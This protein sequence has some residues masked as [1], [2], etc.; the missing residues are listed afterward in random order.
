M[1]LPFWPLAVAI[2]VVCAAGPARAQIE[3]DDPD[4]RPRPPPVEPEE[5]GGETGGD[6]LDPDSLP[7]PQ[8]KP[9]QA[10]PGPE[11]REVKPPEKKAPEKK[12]DEKKPEQAEAAPKPAPLAPIVTARGTEADLE[13]LWKA[14]READAKGD[15][16]AAKKARV[17][18]V[19][20]AGDL[21]TS[22]LDGFAMSLVRSAQEKGGSGDHAGA[23]DDGLAAIEL[24]P[25][26][27][28]A[29]LG[30]A[31]AYL[32]ADPSELGRYLGQLG[33]GL[34]ALL[35]DVRYRRPAL[36][37]LGAALLLSVMAT[38]AAV[39]AMLFVRRGRYFLHDFHHLFPRAAARWQTAAFAFIL[40]SLPLVFRAG[41]APVLLV[42]F[43]AVTFY[44]RWAERAVA[45]VL[46]A[47][48]GLVP[49]GAEHLAE[50]TAFALTPAED[51]YR[52]DRGDV[53]ADVLAKQLAEKAK[54]EKASYAELYVLARLE[55]RRG[56]LDEAITHFQAAIARNA[57]DALALN[58]LGNGMLARGD[59]EG[60]LA[61]YQNAIRRDPDLIEASY[62][63]AQLHERRTR[64]LAPE[65]QPIERDKAAAAMA[66][67]R[68]RKPEL[69]ARQAPPEEDLQLNRLLL[70]PPLPEDALAE[71]AVPADRGEKVR[72]QLSLAVL[73]GV[74]PSLAPFYP[75]VLAAALAGL[76]AIRLR[77]AGSC[78]KCGNAVCRRCDVEL[79]P[80]STMCAQCV[81][82][83]AKTGVVPPPLKVR[84]QIEVARYHDRKDKLAYLFGLLCSGAGH[85]Y[86]GLPV[87]GALYAFVFLFVVAM[88]FFRHGVLRAPYG[89]AP[90]WLRLFPLGLLFLL[91][92]GLSLRGLYRRQSG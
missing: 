44:L 31:A 7:V 4:A 86:S 80:G 62:N 45:A 70:T 10:Q 47:L 9:A 66:A 26:L 52:I 40:L 72:A 59:F 55:L 33:A 8:P 22:N 69:A 38:A 48:V 73:G 84:K 74:D 19:K 75:L 5:P 53:G 14:W 15:R 24:A 12:P 88:F 36:A 56:R 27:P 16:A 91:V 60:A 68:E 3:E 77:V 17:G 28:Y 71:H 85:L 20:L 41:V 78:D 11:K 2:G 79:L 81:N 89:D 18:L 39:V 61:M 51:L 46:L 6:Y 13:R 58:G 23:I 67:V 1:R 42:L 90:M 35:R 29:H 87:R 30:L 34:L 64:T 32:R 25:D 21:G 43:G 57:G 65:L 50:R 92:F 37:D 63:L 82:V 49:V 83:F 76:G 54:A